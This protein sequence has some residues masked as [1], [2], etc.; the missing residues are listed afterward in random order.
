IASE[1]GA[2]GL[3]TYMRTDSM[4]VSETAQQEASRFIKDRF[5]DKYV[6]AK[7]PKYTTKTKGAQEAHEAIRPTGITRIPDSLKALLSRDQLKL[8]TLVWERFVASQ[9]ENAVYDTLRVLVGAGLS[10]DNMPYTLRV[11]GSTIKFDGFL[12]LYEETRDD[13]AIADEDEGRILPDLSVDEALDLL[14]LL[15][16]QHFTQPPP[17][18]TEATLVRTLEEYGIGRPSTYA[19]TVAVIQDREYVTKEEKRLAPTDTGKLVNDML[20]S[21][22]PVIM[23]YQFTAHMEDE[24]D[25]IAEGDI[26]WRP[27]LREFYTPFSE[28]LTIAREQMPN[29]AQEEEIGRA[30]PLCSNP[31]VIRHGRYGKFI[32]CSTYPECRHT[33]PLMEAIG[34]SCPKCGKTDGG[35]VIL[36]RSKRGRVFYG[37]TR[38]PECDFTSWK[39]PLAQ[40][41]PN[42]GGLLLEQSKGQAQC[43]NCSNTYR[44]EELP[45]TSPETA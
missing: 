44:L 43:T 14:K 40:P 33:E 27:M 2:V 25:E 13:D 34:V 21:Y 1:G 23:D 37:C 28:R 22:F 19:P 24:L 42:C 26:E 9:M 38:Y 30:C 6:P 7:P 20:V 16:E 18:Y 12:A 11:S 36:R 10:A 35:Q 17:R 39:R 8:Y 4:N 41:C 45:E 31:L 15:P 29:V 5:G 32:G 3:I